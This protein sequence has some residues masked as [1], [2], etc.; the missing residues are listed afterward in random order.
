MSD[1]T[2][3]QAAPEV[4]TTETQISSD[5]PQLPPG[6]KSLADIMSE[7]PDMFLEGE[8]EPSEP[9]DEVAAE[10]DAERAAV[11]A[12]VEASEES[13]DGEQAAEGATEETA[14]D[15]EQEVA[16]EQP[17]L[18]PWRIKEQERKARQAARAQSE[19][20]AAAL[21]LKQQQ[22]LYDQ[23][24]ALLRQ[25]IASLKETKQ[26]A[27]TIPD[28]PHEAFAAVANRFGMSTDQ[29]YEQLTTQKLS[30]QAPRQPARPQGPSKLELQMAEIAKQQK[31]LMDS[32]SQRERHSAQQREMSLARDEIMSAL[33]ANKDTVGW[34]EVGDPDV[35]AEYVDQKL[36]EAVVEK[37]ETMTV[38]DVLLAV[39]ERMS[40]VYSR[41]PRPAPV[42]ANGTPKP[43]A[44]PAPAAARPPTISNRTAASRSSYKKPTAAE[45]DAAYMRALAEAVK[46]A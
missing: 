42:K 44:K 24:L 12:N 15:T 11:E 22:S 35:V 20:Q 16:P 31:A 43:Q 34:L 2:K 10:A 38:H 41:V 39:D 14:E 3:E 4:A 45:E 18:P 13:A 28:D 37:P 17:K 1:K 25:E 27:P 46:G 7:Q 6:D 36:Y 33:E 21:L 29:F 5:L 40:R 9:V 26:Q 32:M 8:S 30:G 19:E 23:Q